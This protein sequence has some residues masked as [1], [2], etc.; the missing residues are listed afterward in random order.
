MQGSSQRCRV[1]TIGLG[2]AVIVGC[3]HPGVKNI[4]KAVEMFGKPYAIIGG[5]HDFREFDVLKDLKLVCPAH[6][7]RYKSKI[8]LLYPEKY[9]EG[10]VGKE[11][12]I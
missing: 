7:T 9:V 1:I 6:C 2:S 5:L 8:K 4:L 10:G 11:I 12:E 3:S